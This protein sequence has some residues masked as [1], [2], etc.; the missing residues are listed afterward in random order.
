MGSFTSAQLAREVP[1]G[2]AWMLGSVMEA[3][4]QQTL[5]EAQRP[6][7]LETLRHV[8]LIQST[9]SSNRIE[10]VT[11][12]Q[13]RLKPLVMGELEPQDRPEEEIVGY[14]RA[15]DWIHREH[16]HIEITPESIRQLHARAQGGLV[17]D[18]GQWKGVDNDIIEFLP[19]GRR[20]LRFRTT[21]ATEAPDAVDQLCLAYQHANQDS[22]LPPLLAGASLVLDFLC[23]HP[24]RDGNG[25]V[26]RL[27]T[28]LV[29]Y[30]QGF[31]VGRYISLERIVEESKESYYEA[32][33]RSSQAWHEDEQDTI[34]W[35]SYYL[36]TI[37]AAYREFEQRMERVDS[38]RGAKRAVV[39][40]A[41]D[42]M[43]SSFALQDVVRLCPTVS[44]TYV[45]NLLR[46][47]RD[48]GRLVT[49]GRG[50]GARW[51]KVGG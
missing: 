13:G 48:A 45:R 17:G 49:T 7:A 14:R 39:L 24:F 18:A 5:F 37:R 26:S 29:L 38:E 31:R 15:L 20:R 6:E 1:V 44:R 43:P 9:E 2:L 16:E 25:R 30:H 47:R 11:V 23:I 41:I 40:G 21:P 35:W 4:G 46:Q 42:Q 28:L 19:D 22:L 12:E 50:R 33:F 32:L 27:L 34:P 3:K 10:G 51:R 8:A 36:S